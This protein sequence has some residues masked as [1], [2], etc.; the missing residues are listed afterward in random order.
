MASAVVTSLPGQQPPAAGEFQQPS[1]IPQAVSTSSNSAWRSSGSIGPFF[2][3]ISVLAVLA[4]L[5]CILGRICSRRAVAPPNTF[6]HKGCLGWVKRRIRRSKWCRGGDVEMGVNKVMALG[7]Q[8]KQ[9]G[10]NKV[11]DNDQVDQKLPPP[12]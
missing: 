9:D 1:N 6:N 7:D 8:D 4:I 3:V 10:N 5:S 11:K 12:A 2:G